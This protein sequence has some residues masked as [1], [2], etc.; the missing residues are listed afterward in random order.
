MSCS[1]LSPLFGCEVGTRGARSTRHV[2]NFLRLRKRRNRTE[3][4]D[5]GR[6]EEAKEAE[7]SAAC[8]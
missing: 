4:N 3:D 8:R 5:S 7:A 2:E 1:V 6:V